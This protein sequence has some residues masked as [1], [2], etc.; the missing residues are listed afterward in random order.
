MT[1]EVKY[2]LLF[3]V[4][5]IIVHFS[6]DPDF[7]HLR[8]YFFFSIET[9]LLTTFDMWTKGFVHTEKSSIKRRKMDEVTRQPMQV[10]TPDPSSEKKGEILVP[11]QERLLT[12][13]PK[14]RVKS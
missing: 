13:P 2:L 6:C 4:S 5:S 1:I 10:T 12:P 9:F 8:L 14:R 11:L 3:R 7:K